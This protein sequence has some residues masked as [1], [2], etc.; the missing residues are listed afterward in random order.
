MLHTIVCWFNASIALE[1]GELV[2]VFLDV[3]D[4]LLQLFWVKSALLND[5]C[6]CFFRLRECFSWDF[7]VFASSLFFESFDEL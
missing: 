4:S 5:C 6:E 1:Q 3:V 7:F 2:P